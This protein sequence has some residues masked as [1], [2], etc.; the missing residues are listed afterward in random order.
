LGRVGCSF[1]V[2]GCATGHTVA[3]IWLCSK[4]CRSAVR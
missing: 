1:A 2:E 4:R 3:G